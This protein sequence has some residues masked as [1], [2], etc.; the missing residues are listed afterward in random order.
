M[1]MSAGES[2]MKGVDAYQC[3]YVNPQAEGLIVILNVAADAASFDQIK[4]GSSHAQ[5]V[6]I[7]DAAWVYPKNQGLYVT[8]HKG[9]TV[10]DL[11]LTTQGAE[12]K[13]KALIELARTVAGE[14]S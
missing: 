12:Q 3:S 11:H 2:L 6:D 5:K 9:R 14:V 1:V 7:G 13:S 4:A 10:I 8:V